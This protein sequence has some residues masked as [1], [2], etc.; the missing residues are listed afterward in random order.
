M[1]YRPRV[2]AGPGQ[3]HPARR[4]RGRAG[5]TQPRWRSRRAG[6]RSQR[7]LSRTAAAACRGGLGARHGDR[8]APR[9]GRLRLSGLARLDR[10]PAELRRYRD[11]QLRPGPVPC[12]AA[13]CTR[14]HGL[15]RLQQAAER[16]LRDG[17]FGQQVR[18]PARHRQ[19]SA[20]GHHQRHD[21]LEYH[22]HGAE[23]R[24]RED[25]LFVL[26]RQRPG[27]ALPA[28]RSGA[29]PRPRRAAGPAPGQ[30]APRSRAAA[31]SGRRPAA[32]SP[33]PPLASRY[34][35]GLSARSWTA[36]SIDGD[37]TDPGARGAAGPPPSQV[38]R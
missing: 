35:C 4:S 3:S 23:Q 17:R 21:R 34:P 36:G 30:A 33:R 11:R 12:R 13:D 1:M 10:R 19:L 7:S 20:Q 26:H 2:G 6:R 14:V 37:Q 38:I 16:S 9:P 31:R 15:G 32:G 5:G 18:R 24:Q 25:H 22:S 28:G 27:R 8:S 29:P